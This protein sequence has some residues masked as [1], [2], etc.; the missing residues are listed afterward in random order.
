MSISCI[1]WK[2]STISFQL[3][4]SFEQF[5]KLLTLNAVALSTNANGRKLSNE[6]TFRGWS[7]DNDIVEGSS[8][9]PA[10]LVNLRQGQ[11]ASASKTS[12]CVRLKEASPTSRSS[13][14][15]Y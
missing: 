15:D 6:K 3:K 13:R 7:Y 4:S 1:T 8:I 11:V 9:P 5:R 10:I 14:D 2:I 12:K